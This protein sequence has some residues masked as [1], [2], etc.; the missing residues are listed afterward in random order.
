MAKKKI[1]K[2]TK[3]VEK[4]KRISK[5][6]KVNYQ[7]G[8]QTAKGKKIDSEIQA[9]EPGKRISKSGKIYYERRV[10][11]SDKSKLLGVNLYSIRDQYE[12][13]LKAAIEEKKL[14]KQLKANKS[15]LLK[16]EK[17]VKALR[18]HLNEINKTIGN[19]LR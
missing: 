5:Q 11:R 9:D 14:L 13:G 1:K 7:T 2:A 10:N 15:T 8:K 4:K 3:K 6:K 17:K 12:M 19:N 16:N 18:K